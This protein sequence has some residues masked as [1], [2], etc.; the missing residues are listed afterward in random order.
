MSEYDLQAEEGI[1]NRPPTS[2]RDRKKMVPSR[3]GSSWLTSFAD[4]VTLLL[5]FLVLLISVTTM[6]PNSVLW[7]SEGVMDEETRQERWSDGVLRF[8][9][10]GML[11]PVV[12]LIE[13]IDRLPEDLMFDQREIKNAIFQLDPA[14][15]PDYERIQEAAEQ[16]VEIFRDNRGLVVR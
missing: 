5:T 13:N 11:A 8:S 1:E 2:G 4:M 16:G 3:A 7:L 15:T 9:D 12:E 10:W 6:E 14:K